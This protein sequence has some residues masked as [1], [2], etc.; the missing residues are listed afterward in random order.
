MINI[1]D[2]ILDI[3]LEH[4]LILSAIL[5]CI[6]I[7]GV[8]LCRNIIKILMSLEIMLASVNINLVAFANFC[9]SNL[10]Q[11]QTFAIFVMAIAA[12]EAAV[13]VAIL[14]ALNRHKSSTD[15]ENYKDLRG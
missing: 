8:V 7:L 2:L 15:I 12:I 5:F 13:G 3:G 9:D 11:G 6:G 1:T 10:L 4:Y 14:I